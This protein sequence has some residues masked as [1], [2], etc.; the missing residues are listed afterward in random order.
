MEEN[1]TN[2]DCLS[3]ARTSQ[4]NAYR[5]MENICEIYRNL[6]NISKFYD[7]QN[8]CLNDE[9]LISGK[10]MILSMT[11]GAG[12]T[13]VAEIVMLRELINRRRSCI[14]V[15]PY[16]AIAQEKVYSL[17]LFEDKFN[18]CIEEYAASKGRL[19]PIK[20]RK[21]ESVYV[22]TIEKAN[23]LI[24]SLIE[25][26]RIDEIGVLVVDELHMIGEN[27]RG[28][29]IEQGLIKFMQKGTGQI[30]GMSATLSNV[31]QLAKFLNAAVFS[32]KFRPVKLIEKVKIDNSL[33][34]IQPGGEL[35]LEMNLGENKLKNRDPDGLVPLLYDIVP[36]RS[37]LIFCPTK[38]NCENVCKMLSY[39]M[40]KSFRERKKTERL[41][42]V[43]ALKNE[44]DGEFPSL[45]E[46]S[47]TRGVAYHHSGLTADERKIIEGAYQDGII[48][49]IC[50]TSTLAAGVNLPA[51]RVII[52][53]PLVGKES[54]RKAQ[55]LQMI[56]RAGRAGY[57][58]MGEA[59]TVVRSS[60]EESK[61]LD[62]IKGPLPRCNSSLNE[63]A[64]F[65]SFLLDLISLKVAQRLE[66]LE[67]LVQQTLFGIQNSGSEKL[68]REMLEYLINHDLVSVD[69]NGNY[70]ASLF[71][72]AVFS[73]PLSPLV[74]R[75]MCTLLSNNIKEGIVLSSHFHLL[76]M[77]V[78]FDISVDIDW[79]IFYEEYKALPRSEQALL[80]R[81][82]VNDKQLV[83]CFI[84]QPKLNE[85]ESPLRLYISF[86]LHRL[87][88]QET[89]FDVAERFH[90]SRGWL[91]N[92][93][94]ATCSQAS[95]ITR[96]SEKL[97]SFWSLKN[98]LPDLVQHLRDC[99]QQ[100]LIPLLA[101]DGVKRG[102]ARQL[103][104]AGFKT[105]GSIAST[106]PLVLLSTIDHLNR[107]QA[108]AIIR[109]AKVLLRDQLAEKVEELQ[110]QIG[111]KEM[112]ILANFFSYC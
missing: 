93:L 21:R 24:N 74:A 3:S 29:I 95:S 11:T 75:Q 47:I 96:F 30:V 82:G 62:M 40:P 2:C 61:F 36:R 109:S 16:V 9:H 25:V 103:Y 60:Y 10:N 79:N 45:L 86:M 34:V 64:V 4:S 97:P 39:L 80:A 22:A 106:D 101:L 33:Y 58:D 108:N 52:N 13:L 23:L 69:G 32:T 89:F 19:P 112:D 7:W 85:G 5:E 20:H 48:S 99:S 87:W 111:I 31:E 50:C 27:I 70:S 78:P 17:S 42:I 1:R 92:V 8:Q 73:A 28:A 72:M 46:L 53:A 41:A 51:R 100:E 63:P 14:L 77:M 71:G 83:R 104:N 68:L 67:V 107:R 57:D 98:L 81:L 37:V 38:K 18:I 54:L 44:E 105:I 35:E 49:I 55:Y 6:R 94:Q 76:F 59:V 110:E 66:E 15:V 65:S 26:D 12:K 56:G 90:V 88:K 102:R 84:D 43:K 91:Q